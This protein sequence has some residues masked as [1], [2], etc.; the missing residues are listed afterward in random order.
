M[1]LYFDTS[2]LLKRFVEE[3]GS[4]VV[5]KLFSASNQIYISLI[6]QVEAISALRR[7]L[8]DKEISLHDFRHILNEIETDLTFYHTVDMTN[9]VMDLAKECIIQ[10]QL[11]SLDSIQLASA[12]AVKKEIDLFVACDEKL[13]RAAKK[14][15]FKVINPNMT[16]P[17]QKFVFPTKM[18]I[19]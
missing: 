15:K 5:G 14:E 18:E 2:A 7:L 19:Q 13:L 1:N 12:I 16:K 8:N 6:T 17:E 4:D 3:N 9:E 10:H 11:K